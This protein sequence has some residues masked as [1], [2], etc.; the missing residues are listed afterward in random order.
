MTSYWTGL[1]NKEGYN[2]NIGWK[3]K[4]YRSI[5]GESPKTETAVSIHPLL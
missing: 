5:V 2:E 1:A 4:T 3:P